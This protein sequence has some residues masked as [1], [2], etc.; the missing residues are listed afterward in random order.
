[1][2]GEMAAGPLADQ[3]PS[4]LDNGSGDLAVQKPRRPVGLGSRPLDAQ[5]RL[6]Q[7][8]VVADSALPGQG[9]VVQGALGLGSVKGLSRHLDGAQ[10]IVLRSERAAGH[11]QS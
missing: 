8:G 10:E 7:G 5:E 9:K 1:M 4:R 11:G 3:F 6:D 2:D